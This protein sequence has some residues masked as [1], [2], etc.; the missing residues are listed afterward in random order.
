MA[1]KSQIKADLL[2]QLEKRKI[3]G[4]QYVDLVNDYVALW[5]I[6]NNLIKD[7]KK[8]GV[9]VEYQNGQFQKGYKK[10]DSISELNK[11]NG[12]MLRIL[13]ELGINATQSPIDDD[14]EEM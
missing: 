9:S 12:Q 6:K 11:T 1:A 4:S 5:E 10:N 7:I 8:R 2:E 14:D 13:C 3:Y